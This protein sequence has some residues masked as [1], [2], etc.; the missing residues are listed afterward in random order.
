MWNP[1]SADPPREKGSSNAINSSIGRWTTRTAYETTVESSGEEAEFPRIAP[2]FVGRRNRFVYTLGVA[3]TGPGA[4]GL[5]RVVK[6]DVERGTLESF[7]YGAGVIAEEHVLVPR[8]NPRSEDDG[9][10]VGAFLDYRQ[11]LSG[12]AVFDARYIADGPIAKGWLDYPLPP[13]F[14]GEFSP[15]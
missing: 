12:A 11:K 4:W 2:A 1:A 15:A 13:D 9:W 3:P 14:H 5:R 8:R 6:R 7:D 10:V